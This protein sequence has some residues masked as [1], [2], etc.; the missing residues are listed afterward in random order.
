MDSERPPGQD[1]RGPGKRL[2]LLL[3]GTWNNWEDGDNDTNIVRLEDLIIRYLERASDRTETRESSG[4]NAKVHAYRVAGGPDNY[5]FYQRGVGT[6][7]NDKFSGGVFGRGLGDNVRRAYKFLSFN[8]EP[9]DQIFVF[10]FSRGAYTARSIV[11][12]IAAAGLLKR[13]V[14]SRENEEAAWT[15]Y[16]TSPADRL[17]ADWAALTPHVHPR[18]ELRVECVGVFD[19]VGALGIPLEPFRIKNREKYAFHDV[20]LSSI[21][22]VNLHAMAIDEHREPFGATIWR[23]PR[24]KKYDS[25]T[26]QVWFPGAHSDIGGGYVPSGHRYVGSLPALDDITLCWIVRR[27]KAHYSSFPISLDDLPAV[28]ENAAL[29][30]QHNSRSPMYKLFPHAWRTISNFPVGR[31]GL[32]E[33]IVSFDRRDEAIGERVHISALMRLGQLIR[34]DDGKRTFYRSRNLIEVLPRIEETYSGEPRSNGSRKRRDIHIVDWDGELIDALECDR[35]LAI[36]QAAR[37]RLD[38]M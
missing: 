10:G 17:P 24:F 35:A 12:Y 8:Y 22:N 4:D 2:I 9:G 6:G 37:D 26:E 5:V 36:I 21:T 14:C 33:T 20:N 23:R 34:I 25:K 11:G 30:D 19:T 32:R 27:L 29:A 1:G 7:F 13:E 31:L 15:Y 38:Y 16:R 3:D 18:K 28:G